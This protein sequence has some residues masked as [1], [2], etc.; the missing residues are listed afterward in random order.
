MNMD[1]MMMLPTI[2][3]KLHS[4]AFCVKLEIAGEFLGNFMVSVVFVHFDI[5]KWFTVW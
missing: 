2:L 1:V 3:K 4:Y 5:E